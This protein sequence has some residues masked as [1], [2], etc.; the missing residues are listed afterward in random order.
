MNRLI[1]I[2]GGAR[3]GKSTFAED[4]AKE[5]NN[6]YPD[7]KLIAYIAT[8]EG[9]DEE[10]KTR[11][12]EHQKRR[13][14]EFLTLEEPLDI[15]SKVEF[16]YPNHSVIIVECLTTWLANMYWKDPE[17][18][19]M[20]V[21]SNTQN[22]ISLFTEKL[23]PVKKIESV[24]S[25]LTNNQNL[26]TEKLFENENLRDKTLIV[27]SNEIGQGVVPDNKMSRDFR[28]DLGAVNKKMALNAH[29]VFHCVSGI[30]TRIK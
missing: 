1:F 25:F 28:D 17:L 22:M 27:V 5:I 10:F 6:S 13:G 29:Y 19:D 4:L 23:D 2:T 16:A 11:I 3:S 9:M 8:G 30:P 24:K 12:E 26:S 21:K 15:G 7:K 20:R 18:K 14:S